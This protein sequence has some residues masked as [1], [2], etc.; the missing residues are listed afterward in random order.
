MSYARVRLVCA[1]A[2]LAAAILLAASSGCSRR[3]ETVVAR[4]GKGAITAEQMDARYRSLPPQVQREYDGEEGQKRFLDGF[5]EEETWYQAALEAGIDADE[6]VARQIDEAVRRVVIQNYFARELAPYQVL[7]E[8]E[9]R[10]FYETD[11]KEYTKAR[12]MKVRHVQT[13]TAGEAE[14]IRRLILAGEDMAALAQRYSTNEFTAKQGGLLGYVPEHSALIGYIGS[15]DAMSKAIDTLPVNEVSEVIHSPVG[16]QVIRVEEI[17]PEAPMPFEKVKEVIRRMKQPEHD[18]K[19]RAERLETLKQQLGVT[20]VAKGLAETTKSRE[21]AAAQLFE[22]AQQSTGWQ[23]RLD[24][25]NEFMAKYPDHPR[26]SD[27]LFMIGFIYAEELKDY[28]KAQD[29][30]NTL[31]KNHPDSKLA[32]DARFMLDNLGLSEPPGPSNGGA[33]LTN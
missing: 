14:R 32:K 24:L 19:V 21:E 16:Y 18:Q 31:L 27:A 20:I 28:A 29:T 15:A 23:E 26:A 7:T 3:E 22:R 1:V 33:T 6:D 30:F 25:Y 9:L 8:E 5:I 2:P 10:A 12:E 17:V 4:V 11:I 13:K